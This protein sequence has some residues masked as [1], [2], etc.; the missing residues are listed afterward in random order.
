MSYNSIWCYN[1]E[2]NSLSTHPCEELRPRIVIVYSVLCVE[3]LRERCKGNGNLKA[4][5][6]WSV[7]WALLYSSQKYY[8]EPHKVWPP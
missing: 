8:V 3:K 7:N 4:N 1:S 2:D 6:L 5:C